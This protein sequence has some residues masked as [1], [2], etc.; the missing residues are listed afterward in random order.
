MAWSFSET[1]ND[2]PFAQ[3]P[4]CGRRFPCSVANCRY[5]DATTC[6]IETLENGNRRVLLP[7]QIT[8]HRRDE[9]SA[10][11]AAARRRRGPA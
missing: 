8:Q 6:V 10:Q 3:C 7:S 1:D 2:L 4:D 9:L 5:D 11:A